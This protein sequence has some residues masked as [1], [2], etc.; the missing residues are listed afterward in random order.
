[1]HIILVCGFAHKGHHQGQESTDKNQ[2]TLT[3]RPLPSWPPKLPMRL[4][5]KGTNCSISL[6]PSVCGARLCSQAAGSPMATHVP[7]S[8]FGD[9]Q[10]TALILAQT[11]CLASGEGVCRADASSWQPV[12]EPQQ[13]QQQTPGEIRRGQRQEDTAR[14]CISAGGRRDSNGK[15]R[16]RLARS[17]GG[18]APGSP[19][20]ATPGARR[21]HSSPP[22]P[23]ETRE[24][25]KALVKN[26]VFQNLI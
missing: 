5:Q 8:A 14:S 1:M 22:F 18:Q 3:L 23:P 12:A 16:A 25:F 17:W 21:A 20:C 6:R 15:R 26:D 7:P 13:Q 19:P 24:P 11:A 2:K 9:P 4:L 10:P